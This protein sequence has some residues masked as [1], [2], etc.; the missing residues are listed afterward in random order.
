MIQYTDGQAGFRECPAL[1]Q[2]K[3]AEGRNKGRLSVKNPIVFIED[4][5]IVLMEVLRWSDS[6]VIHRAI[7]SRRSVQT[8]W[9]KRHK[10]VD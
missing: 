2:F 10:R 5:V 8:K 3:E 7:P 4:I 6:C 1:V 9:V